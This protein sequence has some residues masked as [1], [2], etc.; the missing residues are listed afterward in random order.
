[1]G[2]FGSKYKL[3]KQ[4]LEFLLENTEF[5]KQQ[6]DVWYAGF[7]VDCPSGSLLIN[8][9]LIVFKIIFTIFDQVNCQ[10]QSLLKCI[11]SSSRKET[12][13]SFVATYFAHSTPT[14]AAK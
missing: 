5:N 4:D 6:I 12:P 7:K 13:T 8:K 3:S 11:S 2:C 9:A 14:T 10:N 1:M